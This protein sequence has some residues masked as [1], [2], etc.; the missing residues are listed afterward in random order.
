M[1]FLYALTGRWLHLFSGGNDTVHRFVQ[2]GVGDAPGV[3]ATALQEYSAARWFSFHSAAPHRF[4][5]RLCLNPRTC[6]D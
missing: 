2:S 5:R 4:V 6:F 3:F 1:D